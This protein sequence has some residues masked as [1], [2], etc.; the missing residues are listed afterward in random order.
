MSRTGQ[1]NEKVERAASGRVDN[2]Y[3][4]Q[5]LEIVPQEVIP[6]QHIRR[7]VIPKESPHRAQYN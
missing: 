7:H 1:I 3:G 2:S 5:I 6:Q 4:S